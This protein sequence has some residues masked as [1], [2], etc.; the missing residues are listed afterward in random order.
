VCRVVW[1][2]LYSSVVLSS[3]LS[4]IVEW[5]VVVV[6]FLKVCCIVSCLI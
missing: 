5:S 1:S 2:G 4:R 3:V 6:I